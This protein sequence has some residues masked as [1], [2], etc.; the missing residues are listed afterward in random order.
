M[1][2]EMISGEPFNPYK[3]CVGSMIPEWL[4]PAPT[5][6]FGAKVCYARLMRFAGE[7]G[8][9]FPSI[10]KIAASLGVSDRQ[11]KRYIAALREA[12]LIHVEEREGRSNDYTFLVH[13]LMAGA[14]LLSKGDNR[15]RVTLDVIGM[16]ELVGGPSCLDG[17]DDDVSEVGHESLDGGDVDVTQEGTD[18]SHIRES[19][20]ESHEGEL[21]Q[22]ES[23]ECESGSSSH[24]KGEDSSIMVVLLRD[25]ESASPKFP[26]MYDSVTKRNTRRTEPR[27]KKMRGEFKLLL[28]QLGVDG[29]AQFKRDW[30]E[31]LDDLVAN[32]GHIIACVE[33]VLA[34]SSAKKVVS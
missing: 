3:L 21:G 20:E 10:K 2:R 27:D 14:V 17:Q 1:T 24:L 29:E 7:Y 19:L 6:S 26:E 8:D 5:L 12:G 30:R 11:A 13:P 25:H 18:Q 31:I 16:E 32:Q 23:T 4:E 33:Q 9:C 34:W 15:E 28:E 22:G